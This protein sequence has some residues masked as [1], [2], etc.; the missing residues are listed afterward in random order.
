MPTQKRPRR[1]TIWL[2][3]G[4]NT[5]EHEKIGTR[6]GGA[7]RLGAPWIRLCHDYHKWAMYDVSNCNF[8]SIVLS[9]LN[10]FST[11]YIRFAENKIVFR[12]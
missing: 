12:Q 8:G 6:E 7:K 2:H 3:L 10:V 1:P 11:N 9:C 4:K 5:C